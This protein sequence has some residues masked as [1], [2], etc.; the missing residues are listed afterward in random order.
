MLLLLVVFHQS[1]SS[2]GSGLVFNLEPDHVFFGTMSFD[3]HGT[4]CQPL[5]K[6]SSR[7]APVVWWARGKNLSSVGMKIRRQQQSSISLIS[8][9]DQRDAMDVIKQQI[10]FHCYCDQCQPFFSFQLNSSLKG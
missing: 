6:I 10:T 5:K 3:R 8:K 4:V 7:V 9:S 2:A 1:S